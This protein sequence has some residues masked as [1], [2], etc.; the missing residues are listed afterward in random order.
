MKKDALRERVFY[1]LVAA[2]LLGIALALALFFRRTKKLNRELTLAVDVRNK[3]FSIISHD[4]R[5]PAGSL[6]LAYELLETGAISDEEFPG[7]FKMLKNQSNTLN[8]TL[9]SLLIWSRS[10]LDEIRTVPLKFVLL[11][12]IKFNLALLEGQYTIKQLKINISVPIDMEIYADKDQFDFIIRNLLS[13]AIKFSY[14]GS[15]IEVTA[16]RKKDSILL[17]VTDHGIG[18]SPERQAQFQS[19]TLETT[20]G[21]SGE[22]GTGLGLRMIKDF[23]SASGGNISLQSTKGNTQFSLS[24]PPTPVIKN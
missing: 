18:I 15:A 6:K 12:S 23:V 14:A 2:I 5:G 17:T 1:I 22:K 4:L 11:E 7:F 21:T 19:G 13:N 24:L 16:E 10:Q 8:E 20:F 9:D 3:L